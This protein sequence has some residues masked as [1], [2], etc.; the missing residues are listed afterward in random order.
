MS[1]QP[2]TSQAIP[3]LD[4]VI[5]RILGS[6]DTFQT[7]KLAAAG[8]ESSAQATERWERVALTRR[9][10]LVRDQLGHPPL[11]RRRL[12]GAPA[13]VRTGAIGSGDDL[14]VL[15]W[16]AEELARDRAA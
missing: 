10:D 15:T 13:P 1:A 6:R 7:E 11:G 16:S 2:T 9:I 12:Q 5:A 8:I 3:T 4:A 14:L